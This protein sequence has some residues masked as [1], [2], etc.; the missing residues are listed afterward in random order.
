MQKFHRRKTHWARHEIISFVE[1]AF[2]RAMQKFHRRK[3]RW[4]RREIISFVENAFCHATQKFHKRKMC[5]GRNEIFVN[6]KS[7]KNCYNKL[8]FF[9][10]E[11]R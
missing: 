7:H 1:N 8:T 9:V 4:A 5:W 10:G 2:R 6:A 11:S 3:T